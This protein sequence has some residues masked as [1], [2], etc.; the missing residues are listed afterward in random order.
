M[1]KVIR[2]R[3][4]GTRPNISEL[5]RQHKLSRA[6]VRRKLANGWDPDGDVPRPVQ[7]LATSLASSATPMA[8]DGQGW[9]APVI[10]VAIALAL[11]AL[12]LLINAQVGLSLAT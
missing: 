8:R 7:P 2:L 9:T 3:R 11:G 6:T 10:L 5:A 4:P 12:G 1:S